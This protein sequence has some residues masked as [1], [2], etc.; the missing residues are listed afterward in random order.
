M[1]IIIAVALTILRASA[2]KGARL[3]VIIELE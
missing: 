3:H 1:K 2:S